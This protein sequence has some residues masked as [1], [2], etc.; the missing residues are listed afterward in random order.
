MPR[1]AGVTGAGNREKPMTTSKK[2]DVVDALTQSVAA[3]EGNGPAD[4]TLLA[5]W[6][7]TQR[8]TFNNLAVAYICEK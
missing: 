2:Q 7:P 1:C 6:T 5:S 8:T 4:Y 3:I